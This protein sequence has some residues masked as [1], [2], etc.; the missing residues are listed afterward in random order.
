MVSCI[1]GYC[2]FLFKS[3]RYSIKLV[4]TVVSW[5]LVVLTFTITSESTESTRFCFTHCLIEE[6]RD[7]IIFS[8]FSLS[9]LSLYDFQQPWCE[10]TGVGLL[11]VFVSILSVGSFKDSESS[12]SKSGFNVEGSSIDYMNE[13]R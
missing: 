13:C 2:R 10:D 9:L 12:S 6:A 8:R 1:K 5:T 11:I 4:T 3:L 7:W